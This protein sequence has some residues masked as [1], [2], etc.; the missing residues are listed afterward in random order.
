MSAARDGL[1]VLYTYVSALGGRKWLLHIISASL[2][3]CRSVYT[4]EGFANA[5]AKKG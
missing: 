1:D 3:E 2:G 5:A 4:A